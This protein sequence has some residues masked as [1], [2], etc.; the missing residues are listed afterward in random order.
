M[1]EWSA[2]VNTTATRYLKG[3]S[4]NTVR[5][6]IVFAMLTRRKRILYG[7]DGKEVTQQVKF[8]LPEVEAWSGGTLD[9]EPADKYRQITLDWRGYKTSDTMTEKERLMNRGV[10]RLVNRYGKI[11]VDM[12]QALDDEFGTEVWNDGNANTD[13][14]HGIESFMGNDGNTVVGD[15]IANPS[16]TY[17]GL[18]TALGNISG[19]WGAVGTAPNATAATDWPGGKGDPEYD[20][21]APRLFNWSSTSW[22][23]GTNTWLANCER[24]IRQA[25]IWTRL[26]TGK[27]GMADLCL[28]ADGLYYDYMN[29]QEAKQQIVVPYK[30]VQDLGFTGAKQEG[31][32]IVTEFGMTPDTGYMLNFSKMEMRCLYDQLFMP[33]G[34]KYDIAGDRYLFAMGWYGNMFFQPKF[35]S[36]FL[37]YA[38]S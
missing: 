18:S 19:T 14:M 35:F 36:K 22:G 23:T 26:T 10:P 1:A 11:M 34:P 37:N 4:D 7:W 12:R 8:S 16:D 29:K 15:R 3:A 33:K 9:F 24:V 2:V 5:D 38:A 6:R 28:L 30:E 27:N 21:L 25:I 32:S 31:V 13:R 17:G 20:Y